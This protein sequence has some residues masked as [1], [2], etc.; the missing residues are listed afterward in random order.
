MRREGLDNLKHNLSVVASGTAG[1]ARLAAGGTGAVLNFT[2]QSA[3][4][5][6]PKPSTA[7]EYRLL[8]V[9]EIQVAKDNAAMGALARLHGNALRVQEERRLSE[10]T[11]RKRIAAEA[12]AQAAADE[13]EFHSVRSAAV[14]KVRVKQG[15]GRRANVTA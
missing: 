11:E 4:H 2:A 6:L 3:Q 9:H 15:N 7:E 10:E 12:A 8:Q 1:T 5:L 13:A 14:S